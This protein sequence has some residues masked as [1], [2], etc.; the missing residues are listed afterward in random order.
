MARGGGVGGGKEGQ[1]SRWNARSGIR[2]EIRSRYWNHQIMTRKSGGVVMRAGSEQLARFSRR[3]SS[4]Y[5][6]FQH[7][8]GP[9]ARTRATFLVGLRLGLYAP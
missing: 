9:H 5:F 2:D 8:A 7:G 1:L 3:L 6:A 4:L